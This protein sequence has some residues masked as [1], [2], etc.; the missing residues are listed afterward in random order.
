[1]EGP[2]DFLPDLYFREENLGRGLV[3]HPERKALT[4]FTNL[5][6]KT[7]PATIRASG[8][9]CH[10]IFRQSQFACGDPRILDGFCR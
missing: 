3:P 2:D 9:M 8:L 7:P 6:T 4:I 5:K 10:G 1:M